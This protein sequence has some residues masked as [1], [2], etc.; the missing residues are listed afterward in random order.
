MR[1]ENEV[2]KDPLCKRTWTIIRSELEGMVLDVGCGDGLVTYKHPHV[3][4]RDMQP[5]ACRIPLVVGDMHHL[6][7]RSSIFD[8]I[9]FSHSLEHTTHPDLA[10]AEAYRA[11]KDGGK[12][13]V[14]TPNARHFLW[15]L[16]LAQRKY[17][18]NKEHKSFLCGLPLMP[19][20]LRLRICRVHRPTELDAGELSFE[21]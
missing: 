18:Y 5:Q 8:V 21:I 3:V 1:D 12:L 14:S 2:M 11:I 13:I 15:P 4:G 7:F 16:Y 10:L 20:C 17:T 9:V 6:P 19:L